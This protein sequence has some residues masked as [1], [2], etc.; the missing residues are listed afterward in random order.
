M[1]IGQS[2]GS[3]TD[4]IATKLFVVGR[5]GLGITVGIHKQYLVAIHEYGLIGVLPLW[6]QTQW[7]VIIYINKACQCAYQHGGLVTGIAVVQLACLQV[8]Y[9]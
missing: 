1:Q 7:Y 4:A 9:A 3:V 8:E 2:V 5:L 6:A